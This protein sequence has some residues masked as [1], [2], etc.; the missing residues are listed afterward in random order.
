MWRLTALPSVLPKGFLALPPTTLTR[1]VTQAGRSC[2][3]C[4][5]LYDAED[6]ASGQAFSYS[7][8]RDR[9]I[10][11][12]ICRPCEETAADGR[13]RDDRWA[14]KVH[15]TTRSHADKLA[16][17]RSGPHCEAWFDP[18]LTKEIL[19]GR[20]G[21]AADQMAHDAEF[22]YA[23]GCSYCHHAYAGMGHGAADITLDIF[24]PR[25][26]PDYG[27]NTRW[28]CMTCQ[29]RKGLLTPEKWAA[30]Q[31]VYRAWEMAK[32]LSAKERGMLFDF[33]TA[34]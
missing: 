10:L 5:T 32:A 8:A 12:A 30:K 21:W 7:G 2:A 9:C 11:R 6:V 16:R 13:K 25:L 22:Q 29:R 26:P 34:A 1:E 24:D 14:S 18:Y 3:R 28:C 15:T 23:N 20:Y 19:V 17:L 31:R 27:T 4:G 33:P